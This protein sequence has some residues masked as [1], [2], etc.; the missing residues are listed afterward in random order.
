MTDERGRLKKII[1]QGQGADEW[2]NHPQ[3]RH[4]ITLQKA[5][6]VNAFERTKFKDVDIREEIW[7]KIQ[8]I[9]SVVTLL[10]RQ[11][12]DGAT[13]EKSLIQRIKDRF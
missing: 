4:A 13:A 12:R 5:E 3:F 1:A 11:V 10:E 7:R 8:A 9:N 2:L 6:L